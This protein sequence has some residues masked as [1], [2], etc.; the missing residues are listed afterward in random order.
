VGARGRGVGVALGFGSALA[1]SKD[2]VELC[3]LSPDQATRLLRALAAK[4]KLVRRGEQKGA[5]YARA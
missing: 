4:G 5:T 3:Q 2:V 1:I